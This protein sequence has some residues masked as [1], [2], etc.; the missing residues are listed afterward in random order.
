M[1][2]KKAWAI[3]TRMGRTVL[4]RFSAAQG[5]I[6]N[7]FDPSNLPGTASL[8]WLAAVCTLDIMKEFQELQF[9]DHPSLG[10][11]IS[12][13]SLESNAAD[14]DDNAFAKK[15]KELKEDLDKKINNN[16]QTAENNLKTAKSNLATKIGKCATKEDLKKYQP[17]T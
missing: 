5:H 13:F 17:K 3:T 4:E 15:I 6:H 16:K 7:K 10:N 9:K 12:Q 14:D 1:T 2:E 8:Y 11:T